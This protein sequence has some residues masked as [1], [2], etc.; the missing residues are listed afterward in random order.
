MR[1]TAR[2][3]VDTLKEIAKRL[4]I[5][6]VELNTTQKKLAEEAQVPYQTLQ[7]WLS[8]KSWVGSDFLHYLAK[9]KNVNINFL[10][11]GKGNIFLS[12]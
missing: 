9:E 6:I 2:K 4:K 10:L 5:I 1:R 8:G 11:I 12:D 3:D 7:N